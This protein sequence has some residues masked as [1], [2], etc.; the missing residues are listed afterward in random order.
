MISCPVDAIIA[1]TLLMVVVL[2]IRVPVRRMFGPTV[3]YALWALPALRLLLPPL[4]ESLRQTASTPI[5]QAAEAVYYV[6]GTPEVA[7][8][9][10]VQGTDYAA[11]AVSLWA[12][13][14]AAFLL[15]HLV[16]Y[17][18]F[19]TRLLRRHQPV[20]RI[21]NVRVVLSPA[22]PG[23]LAFGV[24]ERYVALPADLDARY[25]ADEQALALAHEL[26][27]HARG[28]L[29]ANWVALA[30]LAIHWW[31]PIA[32]MAH[33]AFRADQEL[34]NDARVLR[35]RGHEAAHAYACAILKAAHGGAIAAACH[36]HTIND[37]KGRLRMLKQGPTPTRRLFAGAATVSV[38]AA[39]G[40]ALTASGTAATAAVKA[41]VNETI[42]VDLDAAAAVVVEEAL[43][44]VAALAPIAR[45]APAAPP[46]APAPLAPVIAQVPPAPPTLPAPPVP[47]SPELAQVPPALPA[48]PAAPTWNGRHSFQFFRQ[49]DGKPVRF[50]FRDGAPRS[51]R[52]DV[53]ERRC[54]G[55]DRRP[56]VIQ[57]RKGDKRVTVICTNRIE[58]LAE[59]SARM[60]E[61]HAELAAR[62]PEIHRRA[63]EGALR[64]LD[65][66]RTSIEVN[67]NLT[68]DQKRE[69]LEGIAEGEREIRADLQR[70]D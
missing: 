68:P 28:D 59:E 49:A 67:P 35:E 55:D 38:L 57:Q 24:L 11:L 21:G 3:A 29:A 27:H 39:A 54:P 51:F 5:S 16:Q 65:A 61:R 44:Q 22:A 66:A 18:V 62:A 26:G 25:D 36:L 4:P 33:R 48:P 2:L 63:L 64:G 7:A 19:R 37:L 17:A 8:A 6:V 58:R 23:P 10:G 42:G 1:S 45:P 40:L 15:F 70:A 41:G 14:A 47:P 53:Q 60:A 43:P 56:V 20:E 46:A 50:A 30:V 12:A 13:I 31:N 34:A 9:P 52:F 32:W 69:A